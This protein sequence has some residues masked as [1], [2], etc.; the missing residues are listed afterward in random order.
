MPF[1]PPDLGRLYAMLEALRVELLVVE[2]LAQRLNDPA[3]AAV[4]GDLRSAMSR[5]E[6]HP[7]Y[8]PPR[9]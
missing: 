3:L 7:H 9:S 2:Q 6:Q 1:T 4:A 8:E 5:L